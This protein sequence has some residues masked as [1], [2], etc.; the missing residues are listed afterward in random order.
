MTNVMVFVYGTLKRGHG[1]NYLL[2]G[3][4]F[5]GEAASVGACYRVL[6]GGFPRAFDARDDGHPIFGEV[7]AVDLKTLRNLDRLEGHPRWYRRRRRRFRFADGRKVA[8]WVY[9]MQPGRDDPVD[10]RWNRWVKPVCGTLAWG[11]PRS[12]TE[13]E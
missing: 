12:S 7:F 5:V 2:D 6:D 4:E 3:A 8:A 1:N 9:V 11:R 13:G 10:D